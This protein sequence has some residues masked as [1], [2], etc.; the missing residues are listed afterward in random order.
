MRE[1]PCTPLEPLL[2]YIMKDRFGYF[3]PFGALIVW[4][5][6]VQH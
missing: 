5:H 2:K 3:S 6:P 4:T 1:T